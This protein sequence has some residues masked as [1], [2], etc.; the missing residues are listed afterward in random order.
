MTTSEPSQSEALDRI[1]RA[2]SESG[3]R[4][5]Q[6]ELFFDLVF[7]FAITQLSHLLL[8]NLNVG[9]A[10]HMLLLLLAV[11]WGW[12]YTAWITNWFDPDHLGI[13]FMLVIVMLTSLVMAAT[14]PEAFGA[15]GLTF[16]VAYASMQIGRSLIVVLALHQDRHLRLNFERILAWST[17]AGLLW[18]AGGFAHGS[19]RDLIWIVAVA[20]DY[21]APALGFITPRLGR[22]VT[23][24]WN[25]DGGHLAERCQNFVIIAFGESIV[26]TGASFGSRSFGVSVLAAFIVAFLGSVA[27]WWLY[28][29]RAADDSSRIMATSDDPGRL[30]RTAYTYVH[31]PIAAGIVISAVGDELTISHAA[32]AA[33]IAVAAVVLGGPA[34]FLAGHALFKWIVFERISRPRIAAVIFLVVLIPLGAMLNRLELLTLALLVVVGVGIWDRLSHRAIGD[35]PQPL[36]STPDIVLVDPTE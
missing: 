6:M 33:S 31:L 2:S 7:V 8:E 32:G 35:V 13:R 18:I 19:Y 34:L 12:V 17:T 5:T 24:D 26:V 30:G 22:S 28:F 4:V 36:A 23:A 1:L 25:I 20:V 27:L 16:A 10:L 9:G 14:L 29:N 11:W 3:R 15:R 21:A